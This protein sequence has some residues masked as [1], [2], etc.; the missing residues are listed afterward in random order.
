MKDS[1]LTVPILTLSGPD[2]PF[3]VICDASNF[4]INSAL[5]QTVAEWRESANTLKYR[6]LK[7]AE[8]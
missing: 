1:L 6:Q 5:L 4:A 3:S 8:S 2:P 7:A